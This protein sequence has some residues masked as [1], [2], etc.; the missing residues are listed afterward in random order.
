MSTATPVSVKPIS[1]LG[2]EVIV[3]YATSRNGEFREQRGVCVEDRGGRDVG[4]VFENTRIIGT[5]RGYCQRYLV[6]VAP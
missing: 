5:D 6:R 4:I 2:E 1:L 3:S